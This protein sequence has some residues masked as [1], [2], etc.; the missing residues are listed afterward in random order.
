MIRFT[1]MHGIGNDY[2]YVHTDACPITNP[3]EAAIAWS[4]YHTGIGSDGLVLLSRSEVA[5]FRMRIFNADGSEARMCGNATRCIGK[6]VYERGLTTKT[7]LTLET[8]SGIKTLRLHIEGGVVHSVTVDMGIPEYLGRIELQVAGRTVM[9]D[10]V[11]MGN[12]HAVVLLSE[13]EQVDFET[14]G[15]AIEHHPHW[16]DG[17]NV[18]FVRVR[19]RREID[20]R[21]WERGSGETMACGTGAC[22]SVVAT[23]QNCLTARDVTV[24]LRGGDLHIQMTDYGHVEMTGPAAFV[25]DGEINL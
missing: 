3:H 10:K 23:I 13:D 8:L 7:T 20:M 12:P 15:P 18:E 2:I 11:D 25:F 1:K 4:R 17:V 24:H 9:V 19:S 5:D 6:Y 14:L 22:A 21:V 16:A